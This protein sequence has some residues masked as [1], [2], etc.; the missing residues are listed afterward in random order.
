[1]RTRDEEKEKLILES[2]L[3][4][5]SKTGLSGLKIS[6]L[7][8]EA[9]LATGTVYIYFR[10]KEELV[11]RLYLYLMRDITK[12][13]S[14][15]SK[16]SDPVKLK[17]KQIAYNYL[18][19]SILNPQKAVFFEQYFRSPYYHETENIL[20]EED[21]ILQPVYEV[22]IEGQKQRIIK[23]IDADMLVTMVCGMLDGLAKIAFYTEKNY[24]E[25]EWE[26]IFSV[27]W[28]AIKS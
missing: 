6:D 8:K 12:D 4:I 23:E 7:A 25:S 19:D 10:D 14:A 3:S 11:R 24:S 5:I 22:V 16:P 28:D 15:G 26:L 21:Q 20:K 17:I 2:A 9:K 1:M 13:L 27:V 18:N